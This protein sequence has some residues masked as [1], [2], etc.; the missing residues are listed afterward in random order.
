LGHRTQRSGSGNRLQGSPVD[1]P[2]L[3]DPA[4][5]PEDVAPLAGDE[6]VPDSPLVPPEEAPLEGAAPDDV[7]EPEDTTPGDV[8]PVE[9]VAPVDESPSAPLAASEFSEPLVPAAAAPLD[10]DKDCAL[11][12]QPAKSPR[13]ARVVQAVFMGTLMPDVFRVAAAVI[14][15]F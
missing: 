6:P 14:T 1:V 4:V 8:K 9:P 5:D 7:P 13:K 15:L 2:E 11:P 12:P 10:G 3:E